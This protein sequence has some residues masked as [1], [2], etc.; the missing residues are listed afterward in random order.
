MFF[1]C[2]RAALLSLF[3]G[4]ITSE[5]GAF[6]F[7]RHT[8]DFLSSH[9]RMKGIIALRM[10]DM[11][12]YGGL[13]LDAAL[14]YGTVPAP[15]WRNIHPRLRMG[16]AAR[17]RAGVGRSREHEF[18]TQR[19]GIWKVSRLALGGVENTRQNKKQRCNAQQLRSQHRG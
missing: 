2:S 3:K 17:A 10:C 1:T 11:S 8:G 9:A 19:E 5:N 6:V 18:T 16:T 15:V 7:C 12:K 4:E 13:P 14:E